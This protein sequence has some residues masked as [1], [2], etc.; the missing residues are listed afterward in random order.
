MPVGKCLL[1]RNIFNMLYVKYV[2]KKISNF[3]ESK[4]DYSEN[5]ALFN[6]N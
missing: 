1:V 5:Y 6:R 2:T 4:T 3:M